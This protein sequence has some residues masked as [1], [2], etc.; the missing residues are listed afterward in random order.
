MLAL[1]AI[2]AVCASLFRV[3]YNYKSDTIKS[4]V[5][6][7]EMALLN[8]AIEIFKSENGFYPLCEEM[9]VDASARELYSKLCE[10]V[11]STAGMHRWNI[12]DGKFCDPWN[13]PYIYVCSSRNSDYRLFS[14]GP[15]G[16]IDRGELIDDIYSR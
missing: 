2:V 10:K 3:A 12:S 1:L 7:E 4:N 5:V 15:N 14:M 6:Q 16:R 13:N 8:C 11:D 9:S